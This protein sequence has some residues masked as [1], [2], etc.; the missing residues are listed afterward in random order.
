MKTRMWLLC[1]ICLV[2]ATALASVAAFAGDGGG[3]VPPTCGG[4]TESGLP[5]CGSSPNCFEDEEPCPGSHYG[6][7][8]KYCCNDEELPCRYSWGRWKCC[9]NVWTRYCKVFVGQS[10]CGT[11]NKCM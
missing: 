10:A 4:R 7:L 1:C 11:D 5:N 2:V 9:N 3:G 6:E 8:Y